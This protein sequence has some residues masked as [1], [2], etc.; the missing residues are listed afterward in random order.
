MNSEQAGDQWRG[1]LRGEV[2]RPSSELKHLPAA[3]Y[4]G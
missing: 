2:E 3:G 1:V 4:A